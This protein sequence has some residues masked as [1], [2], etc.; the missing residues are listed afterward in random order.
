MEKQKLHNITSLRGIAAV[1]IVV[2]HFST[3][4]IPEIRQYTAELT[5]FISKNYIWVDFFFILSGFILAYVYNDRF[6]SGV[7]K[8]DYRHYIVSRF[9][10]I[11]P[12]HLFML[13]G[14]LALETAEF[15]YFYLSIEDAGAHN[16][17]PFT[18]R[19]SLP[20]FFSNLFLM[21]TF[22]NGT[23]W[24]EPAWSISAEWVVYIFLPF[25]LPMIFH[26]KRLGKILL[27]VP[28]FYLLYQLN[29]PMHTLD[30]TPTLSL[31]RCMCEATIGIVL[32]DIYKNNILRE[33]LSGRLA[34][35]L[36]F[37][38]SF[39][40][41]FLDISHLIT[42]ALF[43]LLILSAAY[44]PNSSFLSHPYLI[45]LGT[46]SYSIYMTHWFIQSFLLKLSMAL[47]GHNFSENFPAA[48]TPVVLVVCIGL[49]ILSS[50]ITYRIIEDPFRKRL[51]A[52]SLTKNA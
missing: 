21:Q 14:F 29:K 43:T 11:Y 31:V 23:Y 17:E 27:L 51:R 47:T 22:I 50:A 36:V 1:F 49:V 41:L 10:R 40:T 45:F 4:L 32:Y 48:M 5:P 37:T 3:F 6:E 34:I 35:A 13:L 8:N 26:F 2:H 9:A 46:I 7:E 19:R 24:N 42:I 30:M 38:A 12:L 15:M 25:L 39:L 52:V 16:Y 33:A 44:N 18:G 28:A 20:T